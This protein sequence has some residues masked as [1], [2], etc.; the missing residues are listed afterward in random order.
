M[1]KTILVTGATG[2]QGGAV[3]DALLEE[4]GHWRVRALTRDPG[5]A[6]ARA[7]AARGAEVVGGDLA[8]AAS[9]RAALRAG[10]LPY[11]FLRPTTFTDVF[12]MRG[13]AVGLGMMAAVLGR[14][15]T[16]QMIATRDIGVFAR[17]AFA[18][19]FP[20]QALELAGDELTVPQIAART[21]RRYVRMPRALLRAM[22]AESRMLFWFGESGYAA[23]IVALKELHPGLLTLE[24]W[25]KSRGV[26]GAAALS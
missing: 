5:S 8:D 2:N 15:K 24:G 16:L 9:L 25:L 19:R 3:A 4:P 22:G 18:G 11:T 12:V 14:D 20:E 13:A 17:M 23:D 26:D 1:S 21:G 10:G 6:A 7:L